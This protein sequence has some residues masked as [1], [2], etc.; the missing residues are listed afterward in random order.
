MCV[1]GGGGGGRDSILAELSVLTSSAL[2]CAYILA[3]VCVC[4]SV[5]VHCRPPSA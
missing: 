3:C 4:V 1:W 2:R 5:S